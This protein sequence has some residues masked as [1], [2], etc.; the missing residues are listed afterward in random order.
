MRADGLPDLAAGKTVLDRDGVRLLLASD[1]VADRVVVFRYV[2]T[3][4]GWNLSPPVAY[5]DLPRAHLEAVARGL[6]IGVGPYIRKA[7]TFEWL[8]DPAVFEPLRVEFGLALDAAATKENAL[9]PRFYTKE[10]DGLAMPW[11]APTW[12][13]PPYG[14][15]VGKWVA[16]AVD[17]V[18]RG[19]CPVAVLL[20]KATTD[21]RWWRRYVWDCAANRPRPGIE[22]RFP[23][24]GRLGFRRTVSGP[25]IQAPFGSVVIVVRPEGLLARVRRLAPTPVEPARLVSTRI[26][27]RRLAP[28]SG[29]EMSSP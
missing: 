16:K 28:H 24:D 5:L 18:R 11:D 17:E 9:L 19:R 27:L 10:D 23:P 4:E 12:C 7:G 26:R 8:T 21:V 13:N 2:E 22:A 3:A 20:V 29:P 15:T 14:P 25:P 1:P 6:G